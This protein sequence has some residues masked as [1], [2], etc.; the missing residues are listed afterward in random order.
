VTRAEQL[1]W[2]RQG[3]ETGY[4]AGLRQQTHQEDLGTYQLAVAEFRDRR[5]ADRQAVIG[6]LLLDLIDVLS[7]ALLGNRHQPEEIQPCQR[8]CT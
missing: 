1:H 8:P 2:W 3:Y 5:Q 6:A 7:K 4:A